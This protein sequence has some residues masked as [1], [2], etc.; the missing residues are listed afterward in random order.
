MFWRT[1]EYWI[2][3]VV[4]NFFFARDTL[5]LK[6]CVTLISRNIKDLN[7]T[8]FNPNLLIPPP[9]SLHPPKKVKEPKQFGDTLVWSHGM[10]LTAQNYATVHWLRNTGIKYLIKHFQLLLGVN[11]TNMFTLRF[12]TCISQKCKNSVKLSVSFALLGSANIKTALRKLMRLTT[13]HITTCLTWLPRHSWHLNTWQQNKGQKQNRRVE[14]IF[15]RLS[16]HF[17]LQNFVWKRFAQLCNFWHQNFV[18]KMR[19]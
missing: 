6:K 7:C 15:F 8:N 9:R 11:F 4:L 16:A 10:E 18:Q 19:A 17:W 3:P 12:Y 5:N 2:L 13:D 14:L 1:H